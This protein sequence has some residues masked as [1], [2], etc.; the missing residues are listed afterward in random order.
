AEI[1]DDETAA[2]AVAVLRRAVGWFAA[3]G[4][5]VERVLSDNGSAYRSF[6]WRDACAELSIRPKRTRPYRPQTNGKIERFH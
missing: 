1:H 4:V 2:T 3:R 5:T 6:A